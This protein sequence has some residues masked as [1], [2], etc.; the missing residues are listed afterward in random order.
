MTSP[1]SAPST[2]SVPT[3]A[4]A[5]GVSIAKT[6]TVSPASDQGAAQVGDTIAYSYVVTNTGNVTLASVA[7]NDP[8]LGAVTCPTPAAPGL[9]PGASET[10]TANAVYTVTQADVDAGNVIDTAT[11][12]GTDTRGD[13]SPPSNP[14]TSVIQT[15]PA[16]PA[17]S[18]AKTATVS[19]AADQAAAQVGDTIA[20]TY[21]VTNTGNVTLRSVAVNDP[22]LGSVTCPT[23]PAPG[24][25]PGGSDDLHRRQCV[26]GHPGRRG[27]R[28]GQRLGHGHRHRYAGQYDRPERPVHRDRR[29]GPRRAG[30]QHRQD[31]NREPRLR[32]GRGR[33]GRHDR[34]L[35]RGDE[36]RQRRPGLGSGRRPEHRER[37]LPH[38]GR[39]RAWPRAPRKPARPTAPTG[40][41]SPTSTPGAWSTRPQRRN[42]HPGR[43]PARPATW[44]RP[45]FSTVAPSPSVSL[46]K[47]G[48][49]SGGDGNPL[50]VG[51][52]ISYSYLVTNTGNVDLA[53]V[54]VNDPAQGPVA[55]PTPPAP[56]LAPGTSETCTADSTYTV[57]QADVDRGSV[58][59]TATATG[60]DTQG[61]FEP[62]ERPVD[63][64]RLGHTRPSSSPQQ[65][66][67]GDTGSRPECSPGGRHHCV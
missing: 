15:V 7:V 1:V 4:P 37:H 12:T 59:D 36:H 55:C 26:H 54:A 38:S 66:G 50:F 34:L 46:A 52:T 63:I 29:D 27:R 64:R 8:T 48:L 42:R 35:L 31:G 10:C 14:S 28:H 49:A 16:A 23:P 9:A 11:A 56:G 58:T 65:D 25:A 2:V 44:P 32:P 21:L 45:Q 3:V 61:A 19:P 24:L 20:Y 17:V 13:V 22:T 40:S 62:A 5:P 18:I 33:G 39:S 6:G 57:T 51:E 60:T 41:P 30:G 67:P 53:S 47:I 43:L